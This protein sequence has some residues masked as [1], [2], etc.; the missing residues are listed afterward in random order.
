MS[1]STVQIKQKSILQNAI[2]RSKINVRTDIIQVHSDLLGKYL[3]RTSTTVV[4][5][6][7]TYGIHMYRDKKIV[8]FKKRRRRKK[9]NNKINSFVCLRI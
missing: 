5:V 3:C 7:F 1:D 2:N 4:K 8:R 9:G 6:L